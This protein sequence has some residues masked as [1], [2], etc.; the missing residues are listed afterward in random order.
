MSQIRPRLLS[1]CSIVLITS[2]L[3][4]LSFAFTFDGLPPGREYLIYVRHQSVDAAERQI[5]VTTL[6][7]RSG[8]RGE[9]LPRGELPIPPTEPGAVPIPEFVWPHAL[10][11]PGRWSLITEDAWVARGSGDSKYWHGGIDTGVGARGSYLQLPLRSGE[12][13]HGPGLP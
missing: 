10:E 6:E 7:A 4:V 8:S 3:A 11:T 2:A 9:T 13:T 12:R 1:W 5:S